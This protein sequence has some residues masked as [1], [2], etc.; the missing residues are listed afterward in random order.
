MKTK[1]EFIEEMFARF[2]W[3]GGGENHRIFFPVRDVRTRMALTLEEF[4]KI[5][6]TE[7]SRFNNEQSAPGKASPE[8]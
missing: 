3:Q 2:D 6:K 1:K 7:I 4:E 8:P 5:T